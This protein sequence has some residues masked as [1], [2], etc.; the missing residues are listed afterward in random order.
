MTNRIILFLSYASSDKLDLTYLPPPG[1][2][3]AGGTPE[4][5]KTPLEY[6]KETYDTTLR[7]RVAFG[8]NAPNPDDYKPTIGIDRGLPLPAQDGSSAYEPT[9]SSNNFQGYQNIPTTTVSYAFTQT[10]THPTSS[11][12]ETTI[13]PINPITGLPITT[14]FDIPSQPIYQ[15]INNHLHHDVPGYPGYQPAFNRFNNQQT[16]GQ[17]SQTHPNG[18]IYLDQNQPG[19]SRVQQGFQQPGS[20]RRPTLVTHVPFETEYQR[21]QT[22]INEFSRHPEL[23]SPTTPSQGSLPEFLPN[24]TSDRNVKKYQDIS[25]LSPYQSQ[26]DN[27]YQSPHSHRSENKIVSSQSPFPILSNQVPEQ[28]YLEKKSNVNDFFNSYQHFP[29]KASEIPVPEFENQQ[30]SSG[31]FSSRPSSIAVIKEGNIDRTKY[32]NKFER[33]QAEADRNAVIPNYKNIITPEGFEYSFDTSNGIHA[34][35]NGTATDGVKAT[36]SY[37]YTGDD[38]KVYSI[39]YTADENGF[40]PHGDHLPTPP[41]VPEAIQ[42]IIEQ[43]NKEKAAGIIHDGS[44]DEDRYGYKKYQKPVSSYPLDL[45]RTTK[46]KTPNSSIY[47]SEEGDNSQRYHEGDKTPSLIYESGSKKYPVGE[48]KIISDNTDYVM[49]QIENKSNQIVKDVTRRPGNEKSFIPSLKHISDKTDNSPRKQF[50]GDKNFRHPTYKSDKNQIQEAPYNNEN[51]EESNRQKPS[52]GSQYSTD[53]YEEHVQEQYR[54]LGAENRIREPESKHNKEYKFLKRPVAGIRK[55]HNY[56]DYKLEMTTP[57]NK[58]MSELDTDYSETDDKGL[59]NHQIYYKNENKLFDNGNEQR[60]NYQTKTISSKFTPTQ[61]YESSS[62]IPSTFRPEGINKPKVES[63]FEQNISTKR[64]P[65]V[66]GLSV[67]ED[68]I[69]NNKNN[70]GSLDDISG[71]YD[72]RKGNENN[73]DIY[74][75]P[76]YQPTENR[77]DISVDLQSQ[78]IQPTVSNRPPTY[79]TNSSQIHDDV[80]KS[81]PI[82]Q[83]EHDD[84]QEYGN[85]QYGQRLNGK[86]TFYSVTDSGQNM[87]KIFNST[88]YQY[89]P[90]SNKFFDDGNNFSTRYPGTGSIYT[91]RRPSQQLKDA[92]VK[93]FITPNVSRVGVENSAD[94]YEEESTSPKGEFP[95]E[96][97]QYEG[98]LN[99]KNYQQYTIPDQVYNDKVISKVRP[100][101]QPSESNSK[102]SQYN[103]QYSTPSYNMYPKE[104]SQ[105]FKE[106]PNEIGSSTQA[107]YTISTTTPTSTTSPGP[108]YYGTNERKNIIPGPNNGYYTMNG[109]NKPGIVTSSTL[110]PYQDSGKSYPEGA[111]VGTTYRPSQA[112]TPEYEYYEGTKSILP[113]GLPT[114][115]TDTGFKPAENIYNNHLPSTTYR[116]N[117]TITGINEGNTQRID[118]TKKPNE[119]IERQGSVQ[120]NP[121]KDGSLPINEQNTRYQYR[122]NG[123]GIDLSGFG[124]QTSTQKIIGEDFSGPKQQ[125]RFDPKLGYYY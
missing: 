52:K 11:N 125:Q 55:H 113:I 94:N 16:P 8:Q 23:V 98:K 36:G 115:T 96:Q 12:F 99:K 92:T 31:H 1:S 74:T 18:E 105:S 33:P 91:T 42:R 79:A 50:I 106:I 83:R 100:S 78:N 34:D 49:P 120:Y 89:I 76:I 19:V 22:G 54:P 53:K 87:K 28:E 111:P 57:I 122:P 69:I 124:Y 84:E 75:T 85:K 48:Q 81:R 6:P 20:G 66:P 68:M 60:P 3:Y 7:Q 39:V 47:P 38:G 21:N 61:K 24:V 65:F 59:D 103:Q 101:N 35:E 112:T 5:I 45:E 72:S 88:G 40:Q 44:Y 25:S 37:S 95:N 14:P 26:T 64:R 121:I 102:L 32:V 71:E 93:P 97:Y 110:T 51:I 10:T 114:G 108:Y 58:F 123:D 119:N 46:F 43:A 9:G 118:G 86:P 90:P 13:S 4:D 2:Q 41:P 15:G 56:Q 82:A 70:Q 62:D 27:I 17:V 104:T 67:K 30:L 73:Y 107:P 117:Y 29:N 63:N 77:Y 80:Q 109:H 116:P